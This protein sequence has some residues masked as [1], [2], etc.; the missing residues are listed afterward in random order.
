[1]MTSSTYFKARALRTLCEK[2]EMRRINFARVE[3][4]GKTGEKRR[5]GKVVNEKM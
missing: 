2:G 5:R 3:R 4:K 1:M